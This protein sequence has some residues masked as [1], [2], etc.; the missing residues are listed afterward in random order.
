[1]DSIAAK[2]SEHNSFETL[3]ANYDIERVAYNTAIAN[4]KTRSADFF[5]NLFEPAITIPQRPCNPV[6]PTAWT[7]PAID[8]WV[9]GNAYASINSTFTV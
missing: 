6:V 1:M 3:K 7:G 5:K 2:Q 8:W 9:A 4:E